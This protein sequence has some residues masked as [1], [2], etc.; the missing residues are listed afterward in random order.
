[1]D[2][3]K[4]LNLKDREIK[5]I[6]IL[7]IFLAVFIVFRLLSAFLPETALARQELEEIRIEK[8]NILL[9][10]YE[11]QELSARSDLLELE[12]H[13]LRDK[14]I[15]ESEDATYI[16]SHGYEDGILIKS[17]TP[18]DISDNNYYYISAYSIDIEG[19]YPGIIH[20]ISRL[21]QNPASKIVGIDLN[22]N[23]MDM[24]VQGTIVW[25]LYSLHERRTPIAIA[26]HGHGRLDPFDVPGEYINFLY[27]LIHDEVFNEIEIEHQ[28][29]Y[30]IIWENTL[31]HEMILETILEDDQNT[32]ED[33]SE[34]KFLH[35][36]IYSFPIKQ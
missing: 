16:M 12:L 14:F 31:G 32:V 8:E 29:A 25:E 9:A 22:L 15:L 17:I 35:E 3:I 20:F 23:V 1:M 30:E 27:N 18:R 6:Y 5:L 26:S 2:F 28:N 11:A 36:S 33:D 24:N 34:I 7:V 19:S 10:F 4:N 13:R 21:E